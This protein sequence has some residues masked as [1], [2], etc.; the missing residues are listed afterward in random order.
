MRE[1]LQFLEEEIETERKLSKSK[2]IPSEID[3]FQVHLDGSE[4]SLVKNNGDE[5]YD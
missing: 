4:V 1:F 3:G 2:T 5:T